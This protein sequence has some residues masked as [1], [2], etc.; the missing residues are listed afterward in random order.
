MATVQIRNLDDR[1]YD[2][3]RR[4]AAD[5]GRSLQE[6]LR[7]RLEE[8]AARPTLDEA[9]AAARSELSGEVSMDA[10]VAVQ[11]EDRGE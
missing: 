11:H 7:T 1:A 4:R 3:L 6:Y 9:L 10:I 2:I 5:S 8:E